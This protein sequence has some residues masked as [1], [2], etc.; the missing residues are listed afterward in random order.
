M[1]ENAPKELVDLGKTIA[2][3]FPGGQFSGVIGDQAH[4]YGYHRSR[5]AL[6][7]AGKTGDYSLQFAFDKSGNGDDAAG[8]DTNLKPA[9]MRT[10]TSR[11]LAAAKAKDPRLVA[12]REFFGTLDGKNVRGFDLAKHQ[13]SNGADNSHLWHLHLSIKRRYTRNKTALNLIL[14]VIRGD[15]LMSAKDLWAFKIPH[16]D[17]THR[18]T[19]WADQKDM[20]AQSWLRSGA[21]HAALGRQDILAEL[22][23]VRAEIAA[24]RAEI[25]AKK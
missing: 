13:D 19:Y 22:K 18:V 5:N 9:D 17:T 1:G 14:A 8:V 25:A 20:T 21:Y 2:K 15:D 10:A 11:L 16:T 6:K 4:V 24:L 7:A 12:L 23:E 3:T